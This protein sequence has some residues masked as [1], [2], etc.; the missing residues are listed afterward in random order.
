[1]QTSGARTGKKTLGL[2]AIMVT[3][4]ILM[5]GVSGA[6]AAAPLLMAQRLKLTLW[7]RCR[8]MFLDCPLARPRPPKRNPAPALRRI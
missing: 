3:L 2:A 4:A 5:F 7:Q 1:M 6:K 8:R